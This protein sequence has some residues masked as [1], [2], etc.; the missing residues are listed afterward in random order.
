MLWFG[1]KIA[2]VVC[3]SHNDVTSLNKNCISWADS[4]IDVTPFNCDFVG[5]KAFIDPKLEEYFWSLNTAIPWMNWVNSLP[6]QLIERVKDWSLLGTCRAYCT[7]IFDISNFCSTKFRG[8]ISHVSG[9]VLL[10]HVQLFKICQ[11]FYIELCLKIGFVM[12]SRNVVYA[13]LVKETE[14]YFSSWT[15]RG[16]KQSQLDI[17]PYL[18]KRRGIQVWYFSLV[19]FFMIFVYKSSL[20]RIKKMRVLHNKISL[21]L[22]GE[23]ILPCKLICQKLCIILNINKS[24]QLDFRNHRLTNMKWTPEAELDFMY[25]RW[26]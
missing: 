16:R 12:T 10:W 3:N 8:S 1:S 20:T 15:A 25:D 7:G 26:K 19:T 5:F 9:I 17:W 23:A 11:M 4:N 14:R 22:I 21:L 13:V 18:W 6:V 24:W 2:L